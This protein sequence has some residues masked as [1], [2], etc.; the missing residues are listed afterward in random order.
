MTI[1]F[2]I[3]FS[4][5][6]NLFKKLDVNAYFLWSKALLAS[7]NDSQ[8][9]YIQT[10]VEELRNQT[11][12]QENQSSIANIKLDYSPSSKEKWY[13]NAQV[14]SSNNHSE[15]TLN[16]ISSTNSLFKTL[17]D[18]DNFSLNWLV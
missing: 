5:D 17:Q 6:K 2:K 8:L 1:G 12:N 18:S 15:T 16:S 9:Q 7:Q 13:Y 14:S 10:K 3:A 4:I 11:G